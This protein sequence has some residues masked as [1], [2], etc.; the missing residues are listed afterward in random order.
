MFLN[1]VGSY[2]H[3]AFFF[4]FIIGVPMTQ[5]PEPTRI[6]KMK[7]KE[8]SKKKEEGKPT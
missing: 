7:K 5:F 3:A 2:A 1:R 8:I 4:F 6:K